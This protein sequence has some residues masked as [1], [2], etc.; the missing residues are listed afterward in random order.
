MRALRFCLAAAFLAACGSAAG[1]PAV[2][3]T[4]VTEPSPAPP[5]PTSTLRPTATRAPAPTAGAYCR[6]GSGEVALYV[7]AQASLFGA[8][9]ARAPGPGGGGGGIVPPGVELP[10]GASAVMITCTG[11]KTDCCAGA[12]STTA[13]GF[14]AVTNV[15]SHGG[16]AGL[17]VQDR[18]MFLAGVFLGSWAPADPAPE[19]LDLSG[20]LDFERLEPALGQTFFI[21]DGAGKTFV[22]PPAATR[23][24]LGFVDAS[25]FVGEPGFYANNRGALEASISFAME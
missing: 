4:I 8:G 9:Q 24:Y 21:G 18:A 6:P 17:V 10:A 16:I 23:L 5:T 11:G 3:S 14:N 2:E 13:E 12:P 25:F 22:V 1:T 19:R 7:D 15:E 20:K